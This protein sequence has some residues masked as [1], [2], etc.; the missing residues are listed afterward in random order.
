[1]PSAT[2]LNRKVSLFREHNGGGMDHNSAGSPKQAILELALAV[3]GG[4][5]IFACFR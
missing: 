1:M 3:S 2:V 4:V 5:P